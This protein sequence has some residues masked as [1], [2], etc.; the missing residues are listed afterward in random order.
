MNF[1][2]YVIWCSSPDFT[3]L[4]ADTTAEA[5][6]LFDRTTRWYNRCVLH[7]LEEN[8]Y[9]TCESMGICT[10]KEFEEYIVG[11]TDIIYCDTFEV[12]FDSVDSYDLNMLF[13]GGS[14]NKEHIF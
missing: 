8:G 4:F 5:M 1:P 6:K 12:I 10:E 9:L 2:K 3:P 7:C 13:N 14:H 11:K